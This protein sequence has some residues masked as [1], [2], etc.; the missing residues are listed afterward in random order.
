MARGAQCAFVPANLF[1]CPDL[2]PENNIQTQ[3]LP[4]QTSHQVCRSY[5]LNTA[6][7]TKPPPKGAFSLHL[8][9]LQRDS[10]PGPFLQFILTACAL[11]AACAAAERWCV[12]L[13]PA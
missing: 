10:A 5:S 1:T 12:L 2:V 3:V 4:Q 11:Q 13:G 8:I 7:G 9:L 6:M